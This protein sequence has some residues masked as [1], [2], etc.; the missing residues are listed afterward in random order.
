MRNS[1]KH[2][3]LF[4]AARSRRPYKQ[5]SI[6]LP[7][8]TRPEGLSAC[9]TM[10]V[11]CCLSYYQKLFSLVKSAWE[12]HY[13]KYSKRSHHTPRVSSS[14]GTRVKGCCDDKGSHDCSR[15]GGFLRDTCMIM[16]LS[17]T[18]I[19]STSK[20]LKKARNCS[21]VPGIKSK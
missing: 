19:S 20:P 3:L 8:C 7:H 16:R 17:V 6:R 1:I 12:S 21:F 15:E 9:R 4:L 10:A 18:G 13:R 11:S 14:P 2:H 5:Y